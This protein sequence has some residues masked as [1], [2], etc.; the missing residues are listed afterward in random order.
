MGI[1]LKKKTGI[2]LKKGSTISLVKNEKGL[3]KVCVGVNWG[4]IVQKS[5]F[6]LIKEVIDVDLD[7]SVAV[8]DTDKRHIDTVYYHNLVSQNCNGAIRHSGDDLGGDEGGDDGLDNEIVEVDLSLMPANVGQIVFFLNS[9]S[10]IDF[11]HIPYTKIRVLE[12]TTYNLVDVLATYNLSA[13]PEFASF[14][15]MIMGKLVKGTNGAWTFEAIGDPIRAKDIDQSIITIQD[16][17]L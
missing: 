4:A 14:I 1:N 7:C 17:Y 6:G 11:A 5:F 12:G 8:F 16:R 15:A 3:E 10:K 9:Y 2:N 13:Q